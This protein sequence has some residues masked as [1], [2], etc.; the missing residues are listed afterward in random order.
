[1]NRREFHI[2]FTLVASINAGLTTIVIIKG[3]Q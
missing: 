1:M 2:A 3:V